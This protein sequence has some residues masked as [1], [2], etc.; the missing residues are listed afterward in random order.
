[1]SYLE[2]IIYISQTDYETLLGGGSITRN[3]RTLTG[4][5]PN[6]IYITDETNI[7]DIA[8]LSNLLEDLDA[9]IIIK[10]TAEWGAL[11]SNSYPRGTI[12]IYSD[13]GTITNNNTTR[14]VAGIKIADGSTP[15]IDLPFVGDDVKQEIM[16]EITTHINDTVKHITAAE[17][18]KW[19]N[20]INCEDTVNAHNLI[21]NRN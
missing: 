15:I 20:K 13:H 6:Y 18:T 7:S 4:I 16:L 8:G 9:K 3:D 5:N 17:R 1:M 21:L 12:L 10:T 19:N 2:K 14:T 11:Y